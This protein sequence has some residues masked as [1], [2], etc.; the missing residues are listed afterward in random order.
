MSSTFH[1]RQIKLRMCHSTFRVWHRHI[2]NLTEVVVRVFDAHLGIA[3]LLSTC[4]DSDR[5]EDSAF[6]FSIFLSV[7]N[8]VT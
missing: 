5:T 1:P 8:P 3:Q 2:T 7:N 6:S 4:F